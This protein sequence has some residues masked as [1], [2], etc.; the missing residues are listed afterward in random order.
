M[1]LAVEAAV[2]GILGGIVGKSVD[3]FLKRRG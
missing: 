2:C 3:V 1:L